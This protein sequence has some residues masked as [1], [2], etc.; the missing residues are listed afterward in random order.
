MEGLLAAGRVEAWRRRSLRGF[1]CNFNGR[2]RGFEV[3]RALGAAGERSGGVGLAEEEREAEVV[4][5]HGCF[6]GMETSEGL[7][8]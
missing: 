8:G 2:R 3:G 6:R 5:R 7:G 4:S 1:I